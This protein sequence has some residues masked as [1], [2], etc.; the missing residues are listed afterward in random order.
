MWRLASSYLSQR[1][2]FLMPQ[3]QSGNDDSRRFIL[4]QDLAL[5]GSGNAP[6]N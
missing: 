5:F 3:R 1:V 4:M 2:A 6:P